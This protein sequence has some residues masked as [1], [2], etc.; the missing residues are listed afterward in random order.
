MFTAT[1][2]QEFRNGCLPLHVGY[3]Y[4]DPQGQVCKLSN[5]SEAQQVFFSMKVLVFRNHYEMDNDI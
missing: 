4:V 1:L 5:T 2:K 3:E